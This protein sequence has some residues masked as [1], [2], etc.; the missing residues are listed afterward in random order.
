MKSPAARKTDQ[1]ARDKAALQ[2]WI[3]AGCPQPP[4]MYRT[5]WAS[6]DT[7]RPTVMFWIRDEFGKDE[8]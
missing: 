7:S 5:E 3:D 4:A 1:R 6:K 2:S 8:K